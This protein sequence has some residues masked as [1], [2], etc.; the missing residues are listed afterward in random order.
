MS[1][2][3]S[4]FKELLKLY[5]FSFITKVRTF[6]RWYFGTPFEYIEGYV[7]EE[8][9]IVELG[10][11]WGVFTNLLALK[12]Q[13]RKVFGLDFDKNKIY[14]AKKTIGDRENINFESVDLESL[15][16]EKVNSIV[17]Y[18]VLHH[19]DPKIQHDVL[20]E[21]FSKLNIGG[22]LIIKENDIIPYWKYLVS[23]FVEYIAL[24]FKIT[25][26][27]KILFRGRE[28]WLRILTE[29]GFSVIHNEHV[30]SWFGFFVPHSLFVC[31]KK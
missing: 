29:K 5:G 16:L 2:K 25:L 30:K 20:V 3:K 11:G 15:K 22:K 12:S 24:G 7:P 28:E 23:H 14:W 21:C 13:R 27:N 17:I 4:F 9:I 19:L 18:D 8:G 10:C 1:K 6:Q 26:S 31:E